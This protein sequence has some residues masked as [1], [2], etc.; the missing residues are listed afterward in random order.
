ML[1]H[2][3]TLSKD[4]KAFRKKTF[5]EQSYDEQKYIVNQLIDNIYITRD[6]MDVRWKY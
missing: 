4:S 1:M 6:E 5:K 2:Q 3:L